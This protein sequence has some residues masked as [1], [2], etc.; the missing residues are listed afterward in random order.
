MMPAVPGVA[1]HWEA[2]EQSELY[3]GGADY[4]E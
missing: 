3:D 4:A 1:I 2:P